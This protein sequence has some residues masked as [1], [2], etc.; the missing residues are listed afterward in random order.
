M[1]SFPQLGSRCLP[2]GWLFF[3]QSVTNIS[4]QHESLMPP[5]EDACTS[6]ADVV[7]ESHMSID[8]VA[9]TWQ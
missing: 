8:D 5:S 3:T 4:H 1:Q 2:D 9:M 7:N 6:V